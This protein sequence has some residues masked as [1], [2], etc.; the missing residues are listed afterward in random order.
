MVTTLAVPLSCD[1]VEAAGHLHEQLPGWCLIDQAL[2][3][4]KERFPGFSFTDVLLKAATVNSL[5]GTNVYAIYDVAEHVGH[6]IAKADLDK[7]GVELVEDMA[8]E[9]KGRTHP[10]FASKFAHFFVDA[11]RFPMLDSYA[12]ESVELHLGRQQLVQS[13]KGRYADFVG[14]LTKLRDLAN[15][16]C[17][18]R[19]LDYYLW[20]AGQYRAWKK[21]P[22]VKINGETKRLFT[23]PT[24]EQ[25]G[26]LSIMVP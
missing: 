15:L 1:Q 24:E 3:E 14:N 17:G 5:Y 20:L 18:S 22:T 8:T 6:V 23:S 7:A 12:E 9:I 11:E 10:V 21:K 4:L 13:G 26:W 16:Q 19:E 2:A 25:A